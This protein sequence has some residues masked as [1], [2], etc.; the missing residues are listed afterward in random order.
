MKVKK[1][2]LRK[3]WV[4]VQLLELIRK[5]NKLYLIYLNSNHSQN[6]TEPEQICNQVNRVIRPCICKYYG[7]KFKENKGNTKAIWSIVN[8]IAN[9]KKEIRIP[10]SLSIDGKVVDGKDEVANLFGEQFCKIGEAISENPYDEN[11]ET[12][13]MFSDE[14]GVGLKMSVDETNVEELKQITESVKSNYSGNDEINLKTFK[15]VIVYLLLCI[16]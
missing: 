5:R 15:Q 8:E 7:E 11:K 10:A 1:R 2:D 4:T 13:E 14:G 9:K 6:L 3:P 16:V 12:N